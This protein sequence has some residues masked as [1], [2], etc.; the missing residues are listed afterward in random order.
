MHRFITTFSMIFSRLKGIKRIAEGRETISAPHSSARNSRT[1][2]QWATPKWT[3]ASSKN[4][5]TVKKWTLNSSKKGIAKG[6]NWC[7]RPRS[8]RPSRWKTR[9]SLRTQIKRSKFKRQSKSWRRSRQRSRAKRKWRPRGDRNFT[10]IRRS[11]SSRWRRN[12]YRTCTR[13]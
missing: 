9:Y 13:T 6:R 10:R 2:G 4:S 8:S 1:S 3:A 7:S 12:S 5:R 11:C